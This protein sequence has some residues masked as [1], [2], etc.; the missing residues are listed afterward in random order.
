MNKKIL[1]YGTFILLIV[2]AILMST[3]ARADVDCNEVKDDE[4]ICVA[5]NVYY[6][7]ATTQS[8]KGS[9]AIGT[10][11]AM[12]V[13]KNTYPNTFCEVVWQPKQFSWTNNGISRRPKNKKAWKRSLEIAETVLLKFEAIRRIDPTGGAT[14]FHAS[15]MNPKPKWARGKQPSIIIGEHIFYVGIP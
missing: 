5:C 2:S 10:V 11:T 12:R 1:N 14:H 9:L 4:K 3:K 7:A 6:E 8:Y 13:K 15:N